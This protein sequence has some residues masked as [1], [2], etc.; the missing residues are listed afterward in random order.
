[1]SPKQNGSAY[2]LLHHCMGEA[3]G[4]K[5]RIDCVLTI[6]ATARQSIPHPPCTIHVDTYPY[7]HLTIDGHSFSRHGSLV[8]LQGVWAYMEGGMGAISNS[9]AR[10]FRHTHTHAADVYM[11]VFNNNLFM[12]IVSYIASHR[13]GSH[14]QVCHSKRG[15]D[16]HERDGAAHPD[17]SRWP[18]AR[19]AHAGRIRSPGRDSYCWLLTLSCVSGAHAWAC[20]GL[21]PHSWRHGVVW[22]RCCILLESTRAWNNFTRTCHNLTKTCHNL[23]RTC[24]NLTRTCLNLTRTCLNFT[25]KRPNRPTDSFAHHLRFTDFSC[26]VSR[27]NIDCVCSTSLSV[28]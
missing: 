8:C 3:A 24:H 28:G 11:V 20:A 14:R 18:G 9:I 23:T 10:C 21:W 12:S 25:R 17:W 6:D 7:P 1:M 22:D 26:G 27:E 5:V 4:K 13:T 2:V 15:R 16:R 19:G